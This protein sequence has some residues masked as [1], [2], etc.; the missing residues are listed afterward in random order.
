LIKRSLFIPLISHN[1]HYSH[2]IWKTMAKWCI[3]DKTEKNK[4]KKY[5]NR[6]K[7]ICIQ[8]SAL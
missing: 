8:L 1:K 4:I 5:K 6:L 2:L 7:P 3:K